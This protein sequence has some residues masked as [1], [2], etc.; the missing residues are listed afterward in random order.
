MQTTTSQDSVR[1]VNAAGKSR[2]VLVCEHASHFI[3]PQFGT[4]GLDAT[5]RESHIAWDPGAF[6][7]AC[8]MASHLDAKLVASNVSRLVYDCNRAPSAVGA[9]PTQSEATVIQGNANMT[10][11]DRGFRIAN[12]Y[13]PFRAKLAETI[14]ATRDPVIVTVHSFTPVFHGKP[15]DVEIGILH[16]SDARLATALMKIAP[17]HTDANVQINAPYGPNDGVTHTLQEHAIKDGHLNVMLEIRNDLIENT[18]QQGAI[19]LSLSN[20][21][22]DTLAV[23]DVSVGAPC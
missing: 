12:Y 18:L 13:D 22:V 15:R 14:A 8:K 3:P 6:G 10:Q 20:W 4:L 23:L 21:L 19:A 17:T 16:D 9:M 2:V 11:A 1:V 5:A 7:V